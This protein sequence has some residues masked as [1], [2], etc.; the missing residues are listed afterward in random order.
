[1]T[2]QT[3]VR[4]PDLLPFKPRRAARP[5]HLFLDCCGVLYDDA[6]WKRW[7]FALVTR[8][9]LHTH[10]TPFFRIWDREFQRDVACQRCE[11][12]DALAAFLLSAGLTLAQIEEIVAAS[13]AKL[14]AFEERM[15]LFSGVKSTLQRLADDGFELTVTSRLPHS[16]QEFRQRL[17]RLGL[18]AFPALIVPADDGHW[19]ADADAYFDWVLDRQSG[20]LGNAFFVGRDPADL[21]AASRHGLWTIAFNYDADAEAD[22]YIDQFDQLCGVLRSRPADLLAAG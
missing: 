11:F 22:C 20:V 6:E 21:S 10:Y 15:R 13:R 3:H 2:C 9:G 12:G 5:G 17:D 16:A 8:M 19:T 1:M 4:L 18:G 7:I 14:R